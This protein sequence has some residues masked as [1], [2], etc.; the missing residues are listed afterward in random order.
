MAP[1]FVRV[2]SSKFSIN[3]CGDS[4]FYRFALY[5]IFACHLL[6]VCLKIGQIS[7]VLICNKYE[8]LLASSIRN[9]RLKKN[10]GYNS[11][12]FNCL[13]RCFACNCT[14]F[15][16]LVKRILGILDDAYLPNFCDLLL[17]HNGSNCDDFNSE[18][19]SKTPL[20]N[21]T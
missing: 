12:S 16:R 17:A 14:H 13:N 2:L 9:F 21:I 18:K 20:P 11:R 3:F 4:N 7:I 15:I 1:I 10:L 8:I 19:L 6:C 5:R